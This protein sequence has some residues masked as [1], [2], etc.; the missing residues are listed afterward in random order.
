MC[1]LGELWHLKGRKKLKIIESFICL[2]DT[3]TV[4]NRVL[5]IALFPAGYNSVILLKILPQSMVKG[6]NLQF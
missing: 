5:N 3:W 4:K 1:Y 6:E 2:Q